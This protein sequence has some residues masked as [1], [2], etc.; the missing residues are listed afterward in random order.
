MRKWYRVQNA[1]ETPS[2]VD[3]H[4][5][6]FI[7][8]WIDDYWG[9][10]VTAKAFI[11]ELAALP[12][13]VTTIRV[14]L[15]SPG[16][17]VFAALNI[18]NA[19]RDQQTAKG[20]T[21]ETIV[22]GL[23]AS[24]ASIVAMAGSTV[25]MA[26]NALLMIHNPWTVALGDAADLRKTADT[27]DTVRD[28]IVAT[29]Q[30]H[31]DLEADAIVALLDAETW[32]DADEA[33]A[34]GFATDK[35]EGLRAAAS[36]RPSAVSRLRVPEAYAA[37]VQALVAEPDADPGRVSVH[38]D[39][40]VVVETVL[41]GLTTEA[42]PATPTEIL[43]RV[44]AAGLGIDL[45]EALIAEG[46]SLAQ[47][48]ARVAAASAEREAAARRTTEI[49]ALCQAARLPELA[50][51]YLAGAMPL[52]AIRHQLATMQARLDVVE[53][54]AGLAPASRHGQRA[55]IDTTAVYAARNRL[56]ATT[57]KES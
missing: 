19:L 13:S 51:D 46:A 29:Y 41:A 30:W 54:D 39:A 27:L 37:R 55:V 22:D 7:G 45:A 56:P 33:I 40:A 26:D 50:D 31:T 38:L 44:K 32:M 18:A 48:D 10:G 57:M 28:T 5:I 14:H 15:N 8:D 34:Q 36:L 9:F 47:V 2:V 42:A 4:I 52:T 53:I 16:G 20:R 49:R 23:A 6:D 11:K 12:D 17:D 43:A 25:T 24:A 1:E 3:I 21:V 35:V